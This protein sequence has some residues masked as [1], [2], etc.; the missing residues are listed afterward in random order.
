MKVHIKGS[1]RQRK[2]S[3]S[4]L[5]SFS[6]NSFFLNGKSSPRSVW[7]PQLIPNVTFSYFELTIVCVGEGGTADLKYYDR[8]SFEEIQASLY[9]D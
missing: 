1:S 5:R 6:V 9:T 7:F 2:R 3:L 8:A 4:L